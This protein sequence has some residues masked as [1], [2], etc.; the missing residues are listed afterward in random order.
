MPPRKRDYAIFEG[1][2]LEKNFYGRIR[3]LVVIR[4]NEKLL[5]KLDGKTFKSLTAAAKH[6]CGDDTMQINGPEFW[7]APRVGD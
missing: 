1:M 7:K 2:R 3:T 6:V 5:F 4:E